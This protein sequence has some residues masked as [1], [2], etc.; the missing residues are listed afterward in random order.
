MTDK[1]THPKVTYLGKMEG[2]KGKDLE[3]YNCDKC[4]STISAG[5]LSIDTIFDE[6]N[7]ELKKR[8][9]NLKEIRG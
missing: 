4:H 7:G 2:F 6:L 8:V 5:S 3:L 9:R 1:C